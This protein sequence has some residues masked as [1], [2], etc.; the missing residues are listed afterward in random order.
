LGLV[1]TLIFNLTWQ[2]VDNSTW[3]SISSSA[4]RGPTQVARTLRLTAIVVFATIGLFGSLLGAGLRGIAG[5]DSSNILSSA[6]Q[7]VPGF[8]PILSIALIVLVAV[9]IISLIDGVI[10]AVA[11]S[12]LVDLEIL[13]LKRRRMS[14]GAA[15]MAVVV[16]GLVAAWG[17]N[18]V[19]AW[20]GGSVFDF[21]YVLIVAQLTLFGPVIVA[22]SSRKRVVSRRPVWLAI[23]ISGIVGISASVVGG[24][25]GIG[26]LVDGAGTLT[27]VTSVVIALAMSYLPR[28]V[29]VLP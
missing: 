10:L 14:L 3:Q 5:L 21:A 11:Q 17:V 9:S 8:T 24:S 26:V 20:F 25:F 19:V 16:A 1:T 15:R 18:Q 7:S 28:R 6:A 2:F 12:T 22:L 29:A 27:T 13:G 4:D 23:V